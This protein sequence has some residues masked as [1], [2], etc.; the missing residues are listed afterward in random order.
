VNRPKRLQIGIRD[1]EFDASVKVIQWASWP[2][3]LVEAD[4]FLVF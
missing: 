2:P 3:P 1:A 4:Q